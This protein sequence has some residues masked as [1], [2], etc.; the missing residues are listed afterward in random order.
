MNTGSRTDRI[1]NVLVRGQIIV[2][3]FKLCMYYQ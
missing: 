2:Y 1:I 3:L